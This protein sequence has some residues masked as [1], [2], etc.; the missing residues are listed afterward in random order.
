MRDGKTC[1]KSNTLNLVNL[2]DVKLS[3]YLEI[4]EVQ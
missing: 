3:Y 2:V 1:A 4:L